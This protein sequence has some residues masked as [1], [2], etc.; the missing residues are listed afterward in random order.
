MSDVDRRGRPRVVVTGVGVKTPAGNDVTSFWDELCA[1]RASARTIESFDPAH[2]PITFAGEVRDFDAVQYFGPKEARR[3]DRVTQLGFGA[4]ADALGDAGELGADPSRCAVIIATGVGG[5]HTLEENQRLYFEKGPSRVSPFFVPMMMPNATA[6]VVA[7]QLGW[8]GPNLCVATACAAGAHAIG[9]GVRLIRDGTADVVMAGGTEAAVTPL[10]IAAFAR[11]GALS[12]R[13]DAPERASRPF[14]ADRDGFV[15]GEGAGCV[16]LEPLERARARGATIYGEVAGYGRNADAYHITAPSPGGAGA[17]VCMQL[18][19]DD[20]AMEPSALGHV[21]AHG[22]STPLNDAA[23]AEAV[24]KVFGDAPPVVT[25]TKG[26]TGHLI[27]AAGAVEAVAALL[28]VR[29]GIVPPTANLERVGDDIELDVV[30]GSPREI[31]PKPAISNSFGF[32]GH[33]ASLVLTAA[34]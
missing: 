23:E 16:V 28:S 17:A 7:M 4:A 14:D 11:M 32:G 27:G 31:G 2:L 3:Q 29:D 12:S 10:T 33:N 5:L 19:L 34:D 15:I 20:A 30:A 25:S 1:G 18:A 6:G 26:V 24:R 13:N 8:T 22:T 21:N 9:E